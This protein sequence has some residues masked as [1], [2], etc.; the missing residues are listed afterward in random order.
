LDPYQRGLL[1]L[2]LLLEERRDRLRASA[3]VVGRPSRALAEY[4]GRAECREAAG[5]EGVSTDIARRN[6][7]TST[8]FINRTSTSTE[9]R[10]STGV[11]DRERKGR[12]ATS[13]EGVPRTST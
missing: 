3:V 1:L 12:E 6:G 2:L 4:R 11:A 10:K 8:E 7:P 13:T 9:S 5:A